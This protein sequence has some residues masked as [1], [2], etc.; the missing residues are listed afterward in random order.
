MSLTNDTALPFLS[1]ALKSST[2]E[3]LYILT[4]S[5]GTK[6]WRIPMEKDN[7]KKNLSYYF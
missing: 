1:I 4:E 7:I 2:I 3:F 5:F 6:L